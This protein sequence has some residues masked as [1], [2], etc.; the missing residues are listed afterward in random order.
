MWTS[1]PYIPKSSCSPGVGKTW[2]VLELL[3]EFSE[4]GVEKDQE[5]AP[6][7]HFPQGSIGST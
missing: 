4:Q 7:W 3:N 2:Q 5:I 1:V 6:Y